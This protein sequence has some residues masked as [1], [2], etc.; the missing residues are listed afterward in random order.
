MSAFKSPSHEKSIFLR[1]PSFFP[2][3][4]FQCCVYTLIFRD[5]STVMIRP[6]WFDREQSW[7]AQLTVAS[8]KA[9]HYLNSLYTTPKRPTST[10]KSYVDFKKIFFKDQ[11]IETYL[12]FLDVLRLVRHFFE[13]ENSRV[14][15]FYLPRTHKRSSNAI[16]SSHPWFLIV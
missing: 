6:S 9:Q 8:S 5:D 13:L 11:K 15:S 7:T 16:F 14:R 1:I 3:S 2:Y 12:L 10:S 4:W